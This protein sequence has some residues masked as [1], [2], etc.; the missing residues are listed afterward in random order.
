[1]NLIS[2]DQLRSHCKADGD[3][4]QLLTIYGNGAEAA[5]ARLAN[6]YIF[7]DAESM[8]AAKTAAVA[9]HT[10]GW[11]TYD[12]AVLAANAV[13]DERV[14]TVMLENARWALQDLANEMEM[15]LAGKIANDEINS[16]IIDAVLL[17]ANHW[18]E[19]RSEVISGQGA[20]AV[21]MPLAAQNIM[22]LH[23]WIGRMSP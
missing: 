1:M 14:K 17:V 6:R 22:A 13:S 5:C 8:A 12:A 7:P 19:N 9:A 10:A 20:A 23:R 3:D 2:I 21:S 11:A 4:D 16:D 15:T 18:Y